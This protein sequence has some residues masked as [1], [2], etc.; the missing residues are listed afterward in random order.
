[1][2]ASSA[3]SDRT[4][5]VDAALYTVVV[6]AG[7]FLVATTWWFQD[8]WHFLANAMGIAARDAGLARF[9][10]YEVYWRL[11]IGL[12][13]AS[14]VGWAATRLVIHFLSALLVRS[15]AGRLTGQPAT[16]FAVGLLFAASPLAFECLYWA[17]GVVDLLGVLFALL[18]FA[19]WQRGGWQIGPAVALATVIGV[20][21]KETALALVVLLGVHAAHGRRASTRELMYVVVV[22]VAAVV[23]VT[24]LQSDMARSGDYGLAARLAPR[25]LALYGYWLI[26]PPSML[27]SVAIHSPTTMVIGA[28]VWFA[29]AAAGAIQH[30]HGNRLPAQAGC[31]ALLI[32]LP[33]L[34]IG[35]HA[36]PRY[37]YAATPAFWVAIAAAVG[38][39]NRINLPQK[40]VAALMAVVF[41]WSATA[42]QIDARLPSGRPLHRYVAKREISAMAM[43]VVG[44]QRAQCVGGVALVISPR[45][46]RGEVALLQDAIGDDLGIR[47]LFGRDIEVHWSTEAGN[48]RPGAAA[49]RVDG[50]IIRPLLSSPTE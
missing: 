41:A 44:Q 27:K 24:A 13:G 36:V 19:L 28:L 45:S 39:L 34:L 7:Y 50:L 23:A 4:A 26:A 11:F 20:F 21:S 37:V 14:S 9:V 18:A 35:D 22:L 40:A 42:Y 48:A 10:S 8:D 47:V 30:R 25:N 49:F 32:L 17:S 12:F 15:I 31:V 33:A 46:D 29:W 43:R 5:I 38:G 16:G 6:L 3:N 2:K 1:M